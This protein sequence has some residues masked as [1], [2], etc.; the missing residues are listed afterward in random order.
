[1]DEVGEYALT[2][3]K[4]AKWYNSWLLSLFGTYISGDILEVGSGIGNFTVLLQKFGNVTA[5]DVNREYNEK[6]NIKGDARG[7]GDIEKGEYFFNDK[8]FDTIV[9]LNV[10]EHVKDDEKAF[11]NI[12]KLLRKGGKFILLVP[13]HK[14]LYGKYDGLLGHFRRYDAHQLGTSITKLGFKIKKLRYVNWWGA[15][16]WFIFIKLLKRNDFPEKEVGIFNR[17][18]RLLLWPE[19]LFE[20]PF[21]LSVLVVSEK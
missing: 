10:I 2:I 4:K 15:I 5:I 8:K 1:M 9:C 12:Y 7:F 20:F 13:A 16:G 14:A 17:L 3:M 11:S 19:K 21:G 6:N 18:G